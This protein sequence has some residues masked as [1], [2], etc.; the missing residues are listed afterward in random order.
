MLTE[1]QRLRLTL[2]LGALS[3]LGPLSIDMYLPTFPSVAQS[4]GTSVAAVQLTLATYLAGFAVGQLAYGPLADR[5]GRRRPL[6]AGLGLYLVSALACA[7]APSLALLAGARFVQGLGG[8]AGLVISR[9]VVRDRFDVSESSRVYSSLMLVM[10]AAPILAPFL[11]GQVM[12][13]A[14]WRAVFGVLV[15]ASAILLSLIALGL[16]E[17]LPP[18]ARHRLGVRETLRSF[19][20]PLRDGP[21][22]RLTLVGGAILAAMFAYISAAPFVFIG[23]YGV[24]AQRFGLIFGANAFGLIAASQLNRLL[25]RRI[26]SQRALRVGVGGAL[27]AYSAL[28]LAIVLGGSLAV[29]LP[30]LFVGI[31]MFGLVMPNATA[32]A[33]EQFGERAGSASS[34][35]GVLQS[36]CGALAATAVSA[37]ADG[38][39]RPLASVTL[40]CGAAAVVLLFAWPRRDR[41]GGGRA[42]LLPAALLAAV[43]LA[44][45]LLTTHHLCRSARE[46]ARAERQAAFDF[47][48]RDAETRLVQRSSPTSRCCAGRPA[49]SLPRAW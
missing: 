17:S 3:A 20:A 5:F 16:P 19:A 13:L 31:S 10:G 33:M 26:G 44:A 6:L 4:L 21:F 46:V 12:A 42:P 47:Q 41:R 38:T 34:V 48:V 8:C 39:A 36:S 18:E 45:G 27:L 29:V 23:L 15:L 24:P 43:V 11:G 2:V 40:A 22:M 1:R 14:G 30:P 25:V 49:S 28:F 35:L 9:A 37:L 7:L 32:A